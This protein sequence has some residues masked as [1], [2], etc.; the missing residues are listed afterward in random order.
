MKR[1]SLIIVFVGI[2][3]PALAGEDW[4]YELTSEARAIYE[5][6]QIQ[7]SCEN[8]PTLLKANRDYDVYIAIRDAALF[9]DRACGAIIQSNRQALDRVSGLNDT[10]NF[11][12]LQQGQK[13]KLQHLAAVFDREAKGIGDHPVVEFFGFL[14][15]W[16]VSG[17]R[18]VRHA[19]YADAS[20]AETLCSAIMWRRYLYGEQ[21]FK[22]HLYAIGTKE[23][24]PV[25]RL[26]HFYSRCQSA[27]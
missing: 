9:K 22:E 5:K 18:L 23:G 4:A 25:R 3:T 26:D 16:E 7:V 6:K 8:I 13:Q 10:I 20:G 2:S 24:I 19:G 17:V 12:F 27:P 15:D 1:L 11:Y 21:A 14:P